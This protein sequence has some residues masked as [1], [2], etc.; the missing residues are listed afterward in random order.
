MLYAK[1]ELSCER[2]KDTPP[3]LPCAIRMKDPRQ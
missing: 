2:I 3:R 1:L